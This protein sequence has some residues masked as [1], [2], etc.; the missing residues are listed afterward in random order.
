VSLKVLRLFK[1]R[2]IEGEWWLAADMRLRCYDGRWAGF[3]IYGLIMAA[4]Y[5]VGLPATVL[6]ILWRRRHKLFGADTDPFA[7][8]TRRTFGFLY[9]DYG[10]SA[11]WW[12]VE[13]LLRKLLLSAVVVLIDEGSPLQVTL[14]VLVSGWAHV[15]H[16]VYK[17]WGAG[18]VLY[19]L[20]HGSLFVTSFVF[21]MGLLFKV[22]GVSSS[23]RTY[24]AL[25]GLMV[26]LCVAFVA[27]WVAAIASRVV[28]MWRRQ[29]QP[30]SLQLKPAAGHIDVQGVRSNRGRG[31][32]DA[33]AASPSV[34][35]AVVPAGGSDARSVAVD[36]TPRHFGIVNPLRL[37]AQRRTA[38][39]KGDSGGG[40]G[41]GAAAAA[42][43]PGGGTA[44]ISSVTDGGSGACVPSESR[45]QRALAMQQGRA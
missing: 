38:A 35:G 5:V 7:A 18:S 21:L 22:D 28:Y 17:P 15:L 19:S 3:A 39:T 24:G 41:G 43:G 45:M 6:W 44:A 42:P 11:W 1:C 29:R 9:E 14:A 16:A 13:E 40:G 8:T 27:A 31:G 34:S 33:S 20:Q 4:V 23:S 36:A 10:S 25:S 12:E 26:A 30:Q 2:N 37:H 32:D